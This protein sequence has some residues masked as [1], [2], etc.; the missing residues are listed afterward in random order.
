M[1]CFTEGVFPLCFNRTVKELVKMLMF[2]LKTSE[3]GAF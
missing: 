3:V 2:K 1:L